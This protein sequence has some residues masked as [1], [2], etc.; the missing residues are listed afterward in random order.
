MSVH[1][2]LLAQER[3]DRERKEQ[4][5]RFREKLVARYNIRE[6]ILGLPKG[7]P[8]AKKLAEALALLEE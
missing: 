6:A 7:H 8:A 5:R 2:D 4:E 1:D 3:A